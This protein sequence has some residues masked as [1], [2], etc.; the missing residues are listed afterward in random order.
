MSR[1]AFIESYGATCTNWT[2]SWSFVNND[3]KFVIFGAWDTNTKNNRTEIFNKRWEH[4][5]NGKKR[6]FG[7]SLQHIHLIEDEGYS[8]FTFPIIMA[9]DDGSGSAKIQGLVKELSQKYLLRIK[10]RWYAIEGPPEW[11]AESSSETFLEGAT[12]TVIVNAYERDPVA[13]RKCLQHYKPICKVCAFDFSANFG[14]LGADFMHV[15]HL[16]PLS[17]IRKAY[18]VDPIRDLRP[19]CPNCHA[20]LHKKK[21]V[22]SIEALKA[23]RAAALA[24]T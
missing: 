5:V 24:T 12:R 15:H 11:P 20:M 13:R 14:S 9:E 7:Q 23:I 8:L 22:M 2:W 16:R 18:R 3:E 19:V 4:G 21:D 10:N 17:S 1:K 6:G